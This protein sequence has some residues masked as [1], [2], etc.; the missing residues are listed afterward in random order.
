MSKESEEKFLKQ[1]I[2]DD[3]EIDAQKIVDKA[4]S[5]GTGS[6]T[7]P[8]WK[9]TLTGNGYVQSMVPSALVGAGAGALINALRRKSILGGAGIGLGVGAG[10]GAI[11][12]TLYDNSKDY[13][14]GN[15]FTKAVEYFTVPKDKN[16]LIDTYQYIK[17]LVKTMPSDSPEVKAWKKNIRDHADEFPKLDYNKMRKAMADNADASVFNPLLEAYGVDPAMVPFSVSGDQLRPHHLS[18]PLYLLK[19]VARS[20]FK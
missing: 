7:G 8:D 16:G 6:W 1:F 12:Q 5:Y 14:F 18:Y 17:D 11:H 19:H 4:L 2:T 15:P 10:L 9:S 3:G 13:A 20:N